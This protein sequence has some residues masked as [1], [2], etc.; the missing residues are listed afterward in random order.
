VPLSPSRFDFIVII[1]AVGARCWLRSGFS[2]DCS[3]VQTSDSCRNTWGL[4]MKS[5]RLGAA[6]AGV[7]V[8][9][10]AFGAFAADL[11]VKTAPASPT[12][13]PN[14]TG[15]YV[16]GNAGEAQDDAS[17]IVVESFIGL[18]Q[19]F[20]LGT[21]SADG[22]AYGGQIGCDYQV[23]TNWVVGARAMWDGTNVK[24]ATSASVPPG[25]GNSFSPNFTT[26]SFSTATGRVGFLL[27]PTIMVY[28]LGGVAF[29]HDRYSVGA[30][31]APPL[32]NVGIISVASE[33]RTGWDVG[34]GTSWMFNPNWDLWF[35]YDYLDLG[36]NNVNFTPA[37]AIFPANQTLGI[38][39]MV[40]TLLVGVDYRFG[41]PR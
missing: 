39:Q 25:G 9:I 11:P 6:V 40:Q 37:G 10:T 2:W 35:E 15:C 30:T 18:S 23:N 5:R 7:V 29:V 32:T 38:G 26:D 3:A 13:A 24:G 33:T 14:W 36:R 19:A 34:L 20:P 12:V 8:Q 21:A 16:G 27:T 1:V 41:G 22:L 28:G 31:I 17:N 4:N